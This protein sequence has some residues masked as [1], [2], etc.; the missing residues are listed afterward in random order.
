MEY[1]CPRCMKQLEEVDIKN[2]NITS[3]QD[4]IDKES[5]YYICNNC[6]GNTS[7][8]STVIIKEDSLL[9]FTA[10]MQ[11]ILDVPIIDFCIIELDNKPALLVDCKLKNAV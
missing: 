9:N 1:I 2:L 10:K 3:G 11:E 4:K 8:I 5:N 7:S 6:I